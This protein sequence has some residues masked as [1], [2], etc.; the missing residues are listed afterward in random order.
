LPQEKIKTMI[1]HISTQAAHQTMG[2]HPETVVIDVRTP[3]E[4][5]EGIIPGALTINIMDPSFGNQVQKLDKSKS[6]II[7][8]RSGGRSLSA[9]QTMSSM[10]FNKLSNMLGGMIAWQG[11]VAEHF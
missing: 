1:Q 2:D 10:G 9:C 3:A 7:V 8:C 4:W 5:Q 11:P 6:Y